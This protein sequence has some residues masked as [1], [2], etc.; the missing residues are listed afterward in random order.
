MGRLTQI[1][2]RLFPDRGM[3]PGDVSLHMYGETMEF[4]ILGE[5]FH[6]LA[7]ARVAVLRDTRPRG[8]DW[9]SIG[10]N[11]AVFPVVYNYRHALELY[12]KGMLIAAEPALVFAQ[13]QPG[14]NNAVFSGAHSFSR[15]FPEIERVF[16]SLKI[17]FDFGIEGL[18]TREE[19]KSFLE[20]ADRLEVR[21]PVNTKRQPATGDTFVRFNLFEFA[22]TMDAILDTLKNYVSWIHDEAQ[23]RCEMAQEAREAAWENGDH[24]FDPPDH[25]RADYEPAEYYGD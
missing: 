2:M 10:S 4:E 7:K 3:G 24:D 15:L 1:E 9:Q 19:F 25:D 18:K 6:E 21:Y 16:K 20:D 17:P 8:R 23:G 11:Y 12:L 22:A 13:G 5:E 14:L